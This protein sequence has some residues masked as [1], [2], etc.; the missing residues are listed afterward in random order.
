MGGVVK[1]Q[2]GIPRT[3]TH[4]STH[5]A[6]RRATTL[7]ETN[8][9]PLSQTAT[10]S[11]NR[12]F[13]SMRLLCSSISTSKARFPSKRNAC[14]A[15]NASDCVWMETGLNTE[16]LTD[17]SGDVSFE[18]R[19]DDVSCE[20]SCRVALQSA[21]HRLVQHSPHLTSVIV[22]SYTHIITI[23]II[24]IIIVI[25]GRVYIAHRPSR[26]KKYQSFINFGLG[27]Q[28]HWVWKLL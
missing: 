6:R 7:I 27:E 5:R 17:R 28:I 1:Y 26:T 19:H 21:F 12:L 9:L 10:T 14:N 25:R 16:P 22:D 2:D 3:V 20:S 24:I 18:Q 13:V 4:P 8:A 15:R 23:I 11:S